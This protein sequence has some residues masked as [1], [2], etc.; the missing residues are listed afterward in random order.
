MIPPFASTCSHAYVRFHP[1]GHQS[2][3][4]FLPFLVNA[5]LT[6][7]TAAARSQYQPLASLHCNRHVCPPP[8][9]LPFPDDADLTCVPNATYELR[10]LSVAATCVSWSPAF[11]L[12][13][14]S[15][16][17]GTAAGGAAG[18]AAA[19]SGGARG[20]RTQGGTAAAPGGR[21][22]RREGVGSPQADGERRCCLLAVG[23]KVGQVVMWR[24]ELPGSYSLD[25]QTQGPNGQG[26]Q[27]QRRRGPEEQG[28]FGGLGAGG[29]LAAR[30]RFAGALQ[31]H[32]HGAQVLRATWCVAPDACGAGEGGAGAGAA[33]G[34]AGAGAAG[35]GGVPRWS[36]PQPLS[37][38]RQ[39]A[40]VLVTGEGL[41]IYTAFIVIYNVF[42]LDWPVYITFRAAGRADAG[43]R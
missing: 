11:T 43:H 16:S 37:A 40:L 25:E 14:T 41:N 7:A 4:Q 21:D 18:A 12:T 33:A 30:M 29:P 2:L 27:A 20:G 9:I 5:D 38:G 17:G 31:A 19:G 39:D 35:A 1:R 8:Q 10:A 23:N 32:A 28:G 24:L 13:H 15:T 6:S 34:G 42:R 22:G 3:H 36:V 26:Q